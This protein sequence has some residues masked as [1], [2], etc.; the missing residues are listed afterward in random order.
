MKLPKSLTFTIG[1]TGSLWLV[2]LLAYVFAL[3]IE[4]IVGAFLLGCLAAWV[5]LIRQLD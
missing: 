2:A 3:S 1:A 4:L 5:Q